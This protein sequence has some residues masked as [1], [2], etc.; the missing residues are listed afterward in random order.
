[1]RRIQMKP[2]Y[3][4]NCPKCDKIISYK[5]KKYLNSGK[6]NNT[7][8]KQCVK[9][10]KNNP[11][12]GKHHSVERNLKFNK[13]YAGEKSHMTGIIGKNHPRFGTKHTIESKMQI[14]E[15]H[16]GKIVSQYTR[17][18]LRMCR[19]ADIENKYG[20]IAPNYNKGACKIIDEY[21]K[22]HGFNFQHAENGGEYHIKELGYWVDGYDKE[23]NVVIEYDE[24]KHYDMSGLLKDKDIHRQQKIENYLGCKFIRI[25]ENS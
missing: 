8:C 19:L 11:F 7:D 1:M 23:K 13:M 21:G 25:K 20:H 5:S 24:K 9:S 4:R 12:Y 10:G 15:K 18:K 14:G 2:E 3:T 16:R 17:D 22:K 6:R